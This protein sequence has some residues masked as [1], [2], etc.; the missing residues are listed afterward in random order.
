MPYIQ[1]EEFLSGEKNILIGKSGE[2]SFYIETDYDGK[3][4]T[5]VEARLNV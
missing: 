4:V 3:T 5:N 2:T 1:K